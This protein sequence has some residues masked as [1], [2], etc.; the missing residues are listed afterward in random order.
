MI[1]AFGEGN[2]METL[3]RMRVALFATM[4]EGDYSGGRY[5]ALMMAEAL[6]N[7]GH[8]VCVVAD[9]RPIFWDDLAAFPRHAEI[10]F[11]R[12]FDFRTNLPE[13]HFDVVVL[14]PGM[15]MPP[16]FV[17]GTQR[18]ALE[19][20]AHLVFVNFES[21][22]WFNSLSPVPR[23][24][25]RW[26]AWKRVARA[27]SVILSI[28]KEGDTW[29]RRFYTG[30]SPG[31]R[32]EYC[33]PA[34][35][36]PVADAVAVLP[37][38]KRAIL[39]T[40]FKMGEHKGSND[41]EKLFTE[42]LRG[43]TLVLIAGQGEVPGEWVTTLQTK[44]EPLGIAIE[45]LRKP[46]DRAKFAE[47]RRASLLL[48]PSYFEGY[49]YPPIEAQY[50]GLPCVAFDL[51]VLRET[52]GDGLVY[53][54]HG[55]WADFRA[56]IEEALSSE[57]SDVDLRSGI[58][59]VASLD[60]QTERLNTILSPLLDAP[61]SNARFAGLK[62][63][64]FALLSRLGWRAQRRRLARLARDVVYRVGQGAIAF[65]RRRRRKRSRLHTVC[66]FPP[67]AT[68]QDLTNHY[69]RACWYLPY[70]RGH[71]E[72]VVLFQTFAGADAGPG[73]CPEHMGPP[74]SDAGHVEVRRGGFAALRML[75]ASQLVLL[76]RR[77]S[78]MAFWHILD[79]LFGIQVVN[80][81]TDDPSAREYGAY[82][83]L[84]WKCLTSAR[85]RKL[86][87]AES[88]ARFE[89]L[90]EKIGQR[91]YARSVVFGTGPSL[92]DAP[93]FDFSGCL[94]IVCN[95]IVQSGEWLDHIRP[96][97]VCAGDAVSHFGVSLYA[98][99]FRADLVEALRE[100]DLVFVTTAHFGG[101]F[102]FH[103]PEL[104]DRIILID[105]SV[106][107]PNFRLLTHFGLPQLDSTLNIHMLP[108]A[109]TLCDEVWILGCDGKNA[110][111]DNEDFWAHAKGV[112]YDSLVDTGHLCHPTFDAHRQE[113]TYERYLESVHESIAHGEGLGI[114][115]GCLGPSSIPD[116]KMRTVP[117][118][119]LGPRPPYRLA[120]LKAPLNVGAAHRIEAAGGGAGSGSTLPCLMGLSATVD[121]E[122]IVVAAGWALA[123]VPVD[124]V[125]V[126][127]DGV[128]TGTANLRLNRPDILRK[129]PEYCDAL[130]GFEFAC[131]LDSDSFPA[132]PV[133]CEAYSG[134]R[135]LG[136]AQCELVGLRR[137]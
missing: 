39:F 104:K 81:C 74:S 67:F 123:P 97:F 45:V 130:S 80:V 57:G 54:E 69:Y 52:S 84:V 99:G 55:N 48:F 32:F 101:L 71:C 89:A 38:E 46:S 29:A 95:S 122:G 58:E 18:F 88:R 59:K 6:A 86:I 66:Y 42:A 77:P 17:Y 100:R 20:G 53:A 12:T 40:R 44:A 108:L 92:E 34:I 105:Q 37:R 111:Q 113:N 9:H 27:A 91:R 50:C 62:K 109:G 73:P 16:D 10:G 128:V 110:S 4:P 11:F 64:R 7:G 85:K 33:Y 26:R 126:S 121:S 117:P 61:P 72:K 43:Y 132:L 2:P 82:S 3:G 90:A 136:R 115:F 127:I 63:L 103:H 120:S 30:S 41:M 116:L 35:N 22:D 21:G 25:G 76:W 36:T 65:V 23:S 87:L 5:A 96:T 49:G 102:F 114:A 98:Q 135:F 94:T 78:P 47:Y 112:Q 8:E 14:V 125:V 79:F 106:K 137:A 28:S 107:E 1:P 51:P 119:V 13:G 93:S 31:T 56:K 124:K 75:F 19:R 83:S 131:G 118:E 134:G 68:Q 15:T 70:L 129:H 60:T 133:T 24:L